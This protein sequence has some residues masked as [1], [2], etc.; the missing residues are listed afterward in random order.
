V[1]VVT[2]TALVTCA[3][4]VTGV[5][6]GGDG[7]ATVHRGPAPP[8]MAVDGTAATTATGEAV[9]DTAGAALNAAETAGAPR[10]IGTDTVLPEL[11]LAASMAVSWCRSMGGAA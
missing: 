2:V 3:L 10:V 5:A 7:S 1:A 11:G 8:T 4:V 6:T 9:V